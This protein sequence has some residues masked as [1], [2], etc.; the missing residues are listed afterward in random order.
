MIRLHPDS[1]EWILKGEKTTSYGRHRKEG[2]YEIVNGPLLTPKRLGI[3]VEMTPYKKCSLR[4]VKASNFGTEGPFNN[5]E[6]FA[7]WCARSGLSR[8]PARG[9]IH[10]VEQI[11]VK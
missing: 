10:G 8:I 1:V 4:E 7:S 2:T 3:F 6:E 11:K 9:W 5:P